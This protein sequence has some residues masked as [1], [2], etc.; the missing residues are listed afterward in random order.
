MRADRLL[1]ILMMLQAH[2]RMTARALSIELEVSER[3][4]YRDIEALSFSGVPVFT[5]RGPGG[6]VALVDSYRTNLTG[7]TEDEVRALFMLT[8]PAPL[9]ELGI[10][11]EFKAAM[12]KLSAALPENRRVEEERARQRIYLDAAWWNMKEKIPPYLHTVHQAVWQNCRLRIVYWPEIGPF[13]MQVEHL[14]DP[15]GLV[16]KAS[17][18]YLVAMKEGRPR[19]F[20]VS[21]ILETQTTG[22]HFERLPGFDL[23]TCWK[24]QCDQIEEN[25]SSYPVRLRVAPDLLPYLLNYL[26]ERS[27][28]ITSQSEPDTEGWVTVVMS[29]E[30]DWE[31]RTFVLGW[32]RAVEVLEP[33]ILRLSVIDYAAQIIGFYQEKGGKK[34]GG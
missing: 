21:R 13:N 25:R 3:T 28:G 17:V 6:G 8:I 34:N 26:G 7:L 1:S 27:R 23:E 18:W 12:R 9:A 16:A 22:E 14:I 4:I 20:R 11:Q 33:A 32:G 2:G 30:F 29:F 10:S 15:Y 19:V 24:A 31:A 5:E